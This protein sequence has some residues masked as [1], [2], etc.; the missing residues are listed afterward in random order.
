MPFL[1]IILCIGTAVVNNLKVIHHLSQ[2]SN[3]FTSNFDFKDY[4]KNSYPIKT[5]YYNLI[6]KTAHNMS[7]QKTLINLLL[8]IYMGNE[9]STRIT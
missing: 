2:S 4:R 3:F 5:I 6:K 7:C 1:P 8:H 9:T